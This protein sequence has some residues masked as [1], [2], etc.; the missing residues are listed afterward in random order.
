[1][2]VHHGDRY[3]D[4]FWAVSMS[5]RFQKPNRGRST[6][7]T[8]QERRKRAAAF[9][10]IRRSLVLYIPVFTVLLFVVYSIAAGVG[11]S[12][13]SRIRAEYNHS[14]EAVPTVSVATADV[15]ADF[16]QIRH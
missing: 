9:N 11:R 3:P 10:R 15:G 2:V 8:D 14:P 16:R 5:L 13:Y 12:V 4:V 6:W 7:R 1:M